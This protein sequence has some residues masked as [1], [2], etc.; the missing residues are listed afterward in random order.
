MRIQPHDKG[1]MDQNFAMNPHGGSNGP[2]W[3]A[4]VDADAAARFLGWV[5][6]TAMQGVDDRARTLP[7]LAYAQ[8]HAGRLPRSQGC[9]AANETVGGSS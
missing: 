7:G 5:N 4:C 9:T 1:T 6:S 3:P 8:C 2:F